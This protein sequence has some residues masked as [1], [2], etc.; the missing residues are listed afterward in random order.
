LVY[1]DTSLWALTSRMLSS[2]L[3][4]SQVQKGR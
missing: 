1:S 2:D 3:E 4:A